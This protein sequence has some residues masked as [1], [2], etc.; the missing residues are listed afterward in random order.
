MET[1]TINI[2]LIPSLLYREFESGWPKSD[3]PPLRGTDTF[4]EAQGGKEEFVE[5]KLR[6]RAELA[7]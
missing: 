7:I 5:G 3:V 4:R 2:L 6:K 1:Q